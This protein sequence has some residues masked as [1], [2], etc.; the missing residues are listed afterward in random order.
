MCLV[1]DSLTHRN[2]T[3]IR[4]V[5]LGNGKLK[6]ANVHK[7]PSQDNNQTRVSNTS[8]QTLN[9]IHTHHQLLHKLR[10]VLFKIK[11]EKSKK[12]FMGIPGGRL[13]ASSDVVF[14]IIIYD[15]DITAKSFPSLTLSFFLSIAFFLSV[16]L[17]LTLSFFLSFFLLVS[18][19]PTVNS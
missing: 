15:A 14:D 8:I 9:L 1:A 5:F 6:T 18:E 4:F 11:Q 12:Y 16:S 2:C 10:A 17:T 7:K 19:E 3:T 13:N